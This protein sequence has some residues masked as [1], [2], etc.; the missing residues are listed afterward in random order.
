MYIHSPSR[1]PPAGRDKS[2]EQF[3]Q[4]PSP[5]PYHVPSNPPC[6]E[7]RSAGGWVGTEL[8]SVDSNNDAMNKQRKQVNRMPK[9]GRLL[10]ICT[11]VHESKISSLAVGASMYRQMYHRGRV[12]Y[13]MRPF[14][15]SI[16][17]RPFPSPVNKHIRRPNG[18]DF[19]AITADKRNGPTSLPCSSGVSSN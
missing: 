4:T 15:L 13:R 5:P 17:S 11:F 12:A 6:Q 2:S 19:A 3:P 18:I 1:P 7:V 8:R 16:S 14:A 10:M 9:Q